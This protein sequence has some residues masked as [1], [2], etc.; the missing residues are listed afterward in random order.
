MLEMTEQLWGLSLFISEMSGEREVELYLSSAIVFE[1]DLFP[2]NCHLSH[3][4]LFYLSYT[5]S[6]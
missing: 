3:K 4:L 6:S 2:S 1:G 5:T